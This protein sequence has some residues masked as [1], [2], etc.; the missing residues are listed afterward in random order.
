MRIVE[1]QDWKQ[2][3]T[4]EIQGR[5]ENGSACQLTKKYAAYENGCEV[6]YFALD[7]WPL[8]QKRDLWLY[9][10]FVP[11]HLRHR[12]IGTHILA[13]VEKLALDNCYQRVVLVAR[14]LENY[15]KK[16]LRDWYRKHGFK[17]TRQEG[18]DV[19]AKPVKGR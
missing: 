4:P 17:V 11:L 9:E 19:M 3:E 14:P 8:D 6:A 15:S 16:K 1:L 7:W 5:A 2:A 18:A 12:G 10:L 13:E